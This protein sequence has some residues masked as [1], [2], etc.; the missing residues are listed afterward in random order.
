MNSN[1]ESPIDTLI[2]F[3]SRRCPFR[4][5]HCITESGPRESTRLSAGLVRSVIARGADCGIQRIGFTGGEPLL[6]LDDVAEWIEVAEGL[7]MATRVATNAFWAS[8][9]KRAGTVAR[10]LQRRGL[11]QLGISAGSFYQPFRSDDNVC[12][13]VRAALENQLGRAVAEGVPEDP[14]PGCS[15]GGNR[16]PP[17]RSLVSPVGI[18]SPPMKD[19]LSPVRGH[20][21]V[22]NRYLA[23]SAT[24][25][26]PRPSRSWRPAAESVRSSLCTQGTSAASVTRRPRP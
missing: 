6:Y 22:K 11:Q 2:F 18:S 20:S 3:F 13:A 8:S 21:R 26:K 25:P 24:S 17:S 23:S 1:G 15:P 14:E 10:T 4:C 9:R 5:E 16:M 12:R 7:G 19:A